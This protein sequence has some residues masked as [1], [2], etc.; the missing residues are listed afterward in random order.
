M[1]VIGQHVKRKEDPRFLKGAGQYVDDIPLDDALWVT[2]VRSPIAHARITN[3]DA[4]EAQARADTQVFTAEDLKLGT[5]AIPSFYGVDQGFG[6]PYLASEKVR[7]V[8]DIVAVVVTD[9]FAA[10]EDAAELVYVDYEPLPAVI[11][12]RKAIDGDTLLFEAMGTN[13]ASQRPPEVS[14]D[15]LFAGCAVVVNG[16]LVSQRMAGAPIEPRATAAVFEDGRLTAWMSTQTPH[17]DRDG[18]AGALGLDPENARVIAPDVGGGFGP[19]TLGVEDV[20]VCALARRTGRPVRWV[21]TRSENMVALVHGRGATIDFTIGGG[22]DGAIG[23]YRLSV[24]AETGAYPGL[25]AL[26]P[27]FTMMMASGVYDIEKIGVDFT[28]VATNTTTIGPVR[29]AGRPEATQ[30]IE[31]AVDAFAAEIGM[32]PGE[33]RRR[34]FIQPADF[35]FTTASGATYDNGDYERALD[36]A[37]EAV[38]YPELRAEQRRRREAGD[39]IALGIGMCTYVEVTNGLALPEFGAVEITRDGGAILRTGS[40]SHGQGHETTFA[41]IAAERLGL[42]VEKV[43]VV[44]GDTGEVA[45]GTGTFSSKSTQV[46][47]GAADR[48]AGEVVEKARLLTADLIE[49]NPDDIVIDRVNGRFVVAGSP[50]T[51][52]TWGELA[53]RLDGEGRLAELEVETE[54]QAEPTFPFGA[55]VAVVEV[56]TETGAVRV[57]RHVAVDDAGTIINPMVVTGQVHGGV[58]TGIGQAL[59][60]EIAYDPDGNPVSGNFVSYGVPTAAELPPIETIAMVTPTPVNPLGV[61]GIGES[62]TIGATSAVHNAVIDALAPFGVRSVDM[63]ANGERVWRAVERERASAH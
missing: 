49:A 4:S 34:N 24:I 54:F 12:A 45:R 6:R 27:H 60:E 52:L 3:V 26:L 33:V 39:P 38:G 8:G 15:D 9:S 53:R 32:D 22:R 43:T 29:G 42:P 31:R 36:T 56:D 57:E 40:C 25:G 63:P 11:D 46:G 62:G 21:E 7:F 51:G 14:D 28:A 13:V 48:A 16:T 55:H 30:A 23:A 18:I 5:V 20:I 37:L 58:A 1:N 19:K 61:K 44:K 35:P 41:M 50:G 47:G 2:F 10:G 59:F 17:Q